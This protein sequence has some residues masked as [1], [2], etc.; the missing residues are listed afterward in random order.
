MIKLLETQGYIIIPKF[1]DAHELN[2]L[3][4]DCDDQPRQ[5]AFTKH[6]FKYA[7]QDVLQMLTGKIDSILNLVN[8]NTS[9]RVDF[10]IPKAMYIE[11]QYSPFSQLHQDFEMFYILQQN[12]NK[13]NFWI[14]IRKPDRAKSN[15]GVV[16]MDRLTKA[17]PE[18]Q[19]QIVNNGATNYVPND[20]KTQVQNF[21]HG[22]EYVLPFDIREL[23]VFPELSAGDLLLMRGD[24]I[25]QTQDTETDRVAISIR[26]TQGSAVI[27]KKR[28][29]S[30]CDTKKTFLQNM[31]VVV[32]TLLKQFKNSE[33][34]TAQ[35]FYKAL[36]D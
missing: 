31:P 4:E 25:H 28:F 23:V 9:L 16:P 1:L 35:K 18:Y 7:N 12:F 11:N 33:N 14:P 21:D 5:S 34:T 29:L 17:A 26:C 2:L 6:N 22:R 36:R 8:Q 20:T 19:E 13:L 27:N 10:L 24:V 30:G 32:K 3:C 15:L